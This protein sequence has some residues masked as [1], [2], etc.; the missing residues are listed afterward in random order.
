MITEKC[1]LFLIRIIELE[2]DR[3]QN[4]HPQ[5]HRCS[6]AENNRNEH[7]DVFSTKNV[8]CKLRVGD[9][10]WPNINW[11]SWDTSNIIEKKLWILLG[12]ICYYT[13]HKY[14]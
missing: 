14:F 12:K 1:T 10:N 9:L 2:I 13:A 11:N 4:A 8:G 6:S 7:V 5:P 3:Q